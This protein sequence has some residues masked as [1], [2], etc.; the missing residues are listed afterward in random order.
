[1]SP[2]ST[3]PRSGPN[4]RGFIVKSIAGALGTLQ[5]SA[6]GGGGGG[7]TPDTSGG[8]GPV[9][10]GGGGEAPRPVN[11]ANVLR[12]RLPAGS[13]TNYPLQFG[14]P[15][16]AGEIAETPTVFVDGVQVTA[17]VDVKTRHAD[18]SVRFAV[19]SLVLPTLDTTERVIA[20]GNAPAPTVTP[21]TIASM[22]ADF[23]F[24]ATIEV[25]SEG[26]SLAGA[27]VSARAMLSALTDSALAAETSAGGTQSRYWTQGPICTTVLLCDHA[28]KAYDIGTNATKAMRPMFHVQFWPTIRR[29]H[30]RHILEVADVT[31]LKDE[32]GLT[33]RFKT[34]RS[35]PATRLEQAAVN[36]YLGTWQ[37]RAYWGGNDLP[38]AHVRHDV[39]YL[40][41]TRTVPNYDPS[42]TMNEAAL[43]SYATDWAARS[44][45]LQTTGY[46]TKAM[47]ATG[48]RPD[49]GLMPKWDVVALYAG[50]AHMHAIGLAHAELAGS[51]AFYFREGDATKTTFDAVSGQGRVVSKL[52]RPTAFLYDGNGQIKSGSATDK[53]VIDGSFKAS[54]DGWAH[55]HA[56]TPGMFWWQY[57]STG[58]AFWQEKLLQLA[59][60]SQF[61]VNPGLGYSTIANGESNTSLILNG[62]Q[63]R[64]WG[65][66]FRN[67][68][69]AWWVSMEGSAEQKLFDK[70]LRDAIA[71]RA[72]V[73]DLAGEMVGHPVRDAWNTN[74]AKWYATGPTPARPN[75]LAY[76]DRQGVYTAAN[77][78]T[79]V[80]PTNSNGTGNALWMQNFVTLSLGHAVDLG[81]AEA[82]PLLRWSGT[83]VIAIANSKE[84]RH[85]ADYAFP[86]VKNSGE[87]YQS[88][89]DIYDNYSHDADGSLPAGMPASSASGFPG[90]GSPNTYGVTVEGYGSIAAAAIASAHGATGQSAAWSVLTPWHRGSVYYSHDPRYAI[91]PR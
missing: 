64:G 40:A 55:D 39:A 84:P 60:W 82:A 57:L 8:G 59:A 53:F 54:G 66:Q 51:W 71:H 65:W 18:G 36:F 46:W 91:L 30:V 9:T 26:A 35:A 52:S 75:P 23:D 20:F 48:G 37:S 89:D 67:R 62:V 86:D 12:V 72:G 70:S 41:Q 32:I 15:F 63:V 4:R 21:T 85:L 61:V 22:L 79:G 44:K 77:F 10:G 45:A 42:I 33:V 14:R 13:E 17:Q 68:A 6:C 58:Q 50:A 38:L 27:P 24:D 81:Y 49:I 90:G 87:F 29:F 78:P 11:A 43:G 3:R 28:N 47:A 1:M 88:L 7:S 19:V 76:W 69:R 34:G 31:K 16:V 56:H 2:K 80:P 74:H 25:E 5:L 83:L 73:V